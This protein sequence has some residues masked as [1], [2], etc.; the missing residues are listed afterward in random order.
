MMAMYHF[1]IKSDKR[2][3]GST[4]NAVSHAKYINREDEYADIDSKQELANQK[5]SRNIISG[6]KID[7]DVNNMELLYKSPLGS[8]VGNHDAICIS[9]EPSP[10]TVDIGIMYA[11]KN[12]NSPLHVTG[13]PKF[14]CQVILCAADLN[15][16]IK[17]DDPKL[18]DE[19]ENL[20]EEYNKPLK[21]ENKTKRKSKSGFP[22][23]CKSI[24]GLLCENV[25]DGILGDEPDFDTDGFDEL[26]RGDLNSA[27][28]GKNKTDNLYEWDSELFAPEISSSDLETIHNTQD[29]DTDEQENEREVFQQNAKE[30]ESYNQ[31]E[32]RNI[33]ITRINRAEKIT[34]DIMLASTGMTKGADHAAYINR[35]ERFASRGGCIY[36]NHH[37]PSWAKD[38]K[39]FF[40]EADKNERINGSRYKEIEFALPN[41]LNLE[42]QKE[43]ID[44]FIDHHLKDFYYAYAV[45]EKIG[46][47]SNGQKHPHV[48]I[49][50]SERKMDEYEK[51]H[52][53]ERGLFFKTV[54]RKDPVAGGCAKDPKFNGKNRM[55]YLRYMRQDFANIQN[56][57]LAK[58]GYDIQ[59]DHRTLKAQREDALQRGDIKLAKLLDRM[60]ERSVGPIAASDPENKKVIQLAMHRKLREDLAQNSYCGA[61]L[62]GRKLSII[63]FNAIIKLDKTIEALNE[64]QE[65]L[66]HSAYSY[67]KMRDIVVS[68]RNSMAKIYESSTFPDEAIRNA[69]SRRMSISDAEKYNRMTEL[70]DQRKSLRDFIAS[71]PAPGKDDENYE[72]YKE[73]KSSIESQ[74][75]DYTKEITDLAKELQPVFVKLREPINQK[76][77][78]DDVQKTLT[79]E[80]KYQKQLAK[81][82]KETNLYCNKF[83][84]IITDEKERII[85]EEKM[86]EANTPPP[87]YTSRQLL[88]YTIA[89][90]RI[91]FERMQ[92]VEEK[93]QEASKYS[94]SEYA[95]RNMAI[96]IY[97]GKESKKISAEGR[98]LKKEREQLLGALQELRDN[99]SWANIPEHKDEYK[100]MRHTYNERIANYNERFSRYETAMKALRIKCNTPEARARINEITMKILNKKVLNN[101]QYAS[102]KDE[103]A[104]LKSQHRSYRTQIRGL[105]ERVTMDKKIQN[106]TRKAPRYALSAA[107]TITPG[108][109]KEDTPS[110]LSGVLGGD[111]HMASLSAYVKIDSGTAKFLESAKTEAENEAEMD[112]Y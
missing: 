16:K 63:S 104:T 42:Q 65:I 30:T 40:E 48:H 73:I 19:F 39:D 13:T 33:S 8:I 37:L 103:L 93:I 110:I 64:S 12:N 99:A 7:H 61:I 75:N 2:A 51:E 105:R 107:T 20:K 53:R 25:F 62:E 11:F 6:N 22:D 34:M 76:L 84:R 95:A 83:N 31:K 41:E 36:T 47:L 27:T 72:I 102:L 108:K 17:F 68:R 52:E 77:I 67:D 46:A 18:Q 112:M 96:S 55:A 89:N 45:H 3:N 82:T 97:T 14:K 71:Y 56:N 58:Y 43:I 100:E 23:F 98:E 44:T 15:L 70:A 80:L 94:I 29:S 79:K 59:V 109:R 35:E 21:G 9:D 106:K 32:K 81:L 88:D 74:A 60:P 54:A 4:T 87:E 10:A 85:S 101:K 91:I 57:I 69:I 92:E 26:L 49:M 90:Q 1:R 5:F 28:A 111:E 38:A 24:P 50:F 78:R 66:E 86:E